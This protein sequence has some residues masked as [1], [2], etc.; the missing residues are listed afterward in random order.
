MP[1]GL[2]LSDEYKK[3]CKETK[4]LKD[5]AGGKP[6]DLLTS[7]Y[8]PP[9][10]SELTSEAEA[11]QKYLNRLKRT[12][13]TVV[14][15]HVVES[16]VY[17]CSRDI[18]VAYP[19][20][21][22]ED[23]V[24]DEIKVNTTGADESV[25]L[26]LT[27]SLENYF[28]DGMLA[29]LVEQ[30]KDVTSDT[31]SYQVRYDSTAILHVER[32]DHNGGY[33]LKRVR[34]LNAPKLL[35]D[36]RRQQWVREYF[37]DTPA[38]NYKWKDW[39]SKPH[40]ADEAIDL[41][42]VEFEATEEQDGE[43]D[44]I[45]CVIMGRGPIDS[46]IRNVWAKDK[47]ILNY[48]S[49]IC[50]T[51]YAQGFARVVMGNTDPDKVKAVDE[52]QAMVTPD[53][54]S[55]VQLNPV[56]PAAAREERNFLMRRAV[57]TGMRQFRQLH[58]DQTKQVSS[59]ESK[60]KDMKDLEAF[61]NQTLD[62]FEVW[63]KKVYQLHLRFLNSALSTDVLNEVKVQINREFDL[64]DIEHEIQSDLLLV[65]L[66]KEFGEAGREIRKHVVKRR[67]SDMRIV[68]GEEADERQEME[69]LLQA[70]QDEKPPERENVIQ[71]ANRF[72]QFRDQQNSE[73]EN[74]AEGTEPAR[75]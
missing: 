8:I 59:A 12:P 4:P 15:G 3:R 56:D 41:E 58:S 1:Q 38:S 49:V 18:T 22:K 2:E 20:R 52:H 10:K 72:R 75:A 65:N 50:N 27:R 6:E 68:P 69:A 9:Y 51:V 23:P 53:P 45:P 42:R 36:G 55:V 31:R 21:Y 13:I 30:P 70:I 24:L 33:K 5:F 16:H 64:G 73:I 17:T 48:N 28:R 14:S 46:A 26:S 67:V 29:T 39:Y 44:Q 57:M 35:E 19:E 40:K 25:Q 32:F 47:A 34:L 71:A 74:D 61:Y 54:I 66:S 63:L 37:M 60:A 62:M 43:F 7:E 11:D